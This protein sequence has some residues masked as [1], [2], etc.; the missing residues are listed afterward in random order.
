MDNASVKTTNILG[1]KIIELNVLEE[2]V[3][4]LGKC[5]YCKKKSLEEFYNCESFKCLQCFICGKSFW[6]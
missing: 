4:K 6:I 1:M 3:T 5:P 2:Q